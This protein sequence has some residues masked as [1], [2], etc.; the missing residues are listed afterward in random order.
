MANDMHIA[1]IMAG[2]RKT[3]LQQHEKAQPNG[4]DTHGG[5]LRDYARGRKRK[6]AAL[7]LQPT[8]IQIDKTP[9]LAGQFFQA[10]SDMKTVIF[11]F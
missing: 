9:A 6:Y 3:G 7:D 2:R 5:D 1:D 11:G 8:Q 10:W 4:Q